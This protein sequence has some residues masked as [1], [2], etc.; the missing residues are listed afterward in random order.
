MFPESKNQD[1]AN[2]LTDLIATEKIQVDTTRALVGG[3]LAAATTLIGAWTVG[4]ASGLETFA[5]LQ[6]SL[7][8]ARSFAGT[9]TL[10][11]GNIL[12]L[13]LTLISLSSAANIDLKYGHYLRIKQISWVTAGTLVA[14]ILVYLLL[15]IPLSEAEEKT[16]PWYAYAYYTTLAVSSL[17]GGALISIV[18]MLYNAAKDIILVLS[19]KEEEGKHMVRAEKE[20][21]EEEKEE[22]VEER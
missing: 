13:M 11:L 20:E 22:E 14:A 7:E 15:N 19:P 9:I 4:T 1:A 6:T 12:A 10:A 5:L 21:E 18:L 2:Q 16:L 3:G 8:T 17:L